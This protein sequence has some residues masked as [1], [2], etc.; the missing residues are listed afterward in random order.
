M[1][2]DETRQQLIVSN[3]RQASETLAGF[4]QQFAHAHGLDEETHHDLRLAMEEAFTN[5]VSY[6]YDT[7]DEHPVTIE[8][9]HSEQRLTIRFIDEGIA[10]NPLQDC[11]NCMENNRHEH[12]GMGIHLIKSLTDEQ[13]YKRIDD[14]NIFTLIKYYT[15][16][17]QRT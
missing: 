13:E 3:S 9:T 5:I 4:L 8:L 1:R 12:G 7:Q 16:A 2:R 17:K 14:R 11:I 10:F 6:A 15:Q